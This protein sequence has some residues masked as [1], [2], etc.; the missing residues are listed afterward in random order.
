[1]PAH[2]RLRRR[3]FRSFTRGSVERMRSTIESLTDVLLEDLAGSGGG[4]LTERRAFRLPIAVI[5]E[6][7]GV[8]GEDLPAFRDRVF[9][10]TAAFEIGVTRDQLDAAD[11]AAVEC[12]KYFDDLIAAK[13]A[14][15]DDGLISRLIHPEDDVDPLT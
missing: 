14:H 13:R 15:P 4:D 8:A 7:L 10:L 5:G 2:T 6:M 1:G 3:V 12:M 11:V 9:A